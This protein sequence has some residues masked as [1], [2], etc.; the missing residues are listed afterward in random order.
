MRHEI[1]VHSAWGVGRIAEELFDV[2]V[3]HTLTGP[4][5]VSD[6]PVET[7]PLTRAHRSRLGVAEKWDLYI[8]GVER[9]TG[10]SELTDPVEQR[11][12]F[13][14]QTALGAAGDDEAMVLDED[15]LQ[16]LEYAMPPTGGVGLGIDRLLT[17][18]TEA[19]T[20]RDTILF[21]LVR[22]LGSP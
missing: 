17:V 8:G 13:A 1:E 2:L 21:P 6:Y 20:L 9:G 19:V 16:A 10:Y 3:A 22:P 4:V 15:F 14:A 11:A 7:S 12:R 5:F 18:L